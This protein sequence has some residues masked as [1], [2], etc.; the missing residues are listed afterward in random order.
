MEGVNTEFEKY[1]KSKF[2][3]FTFDFK[4]LYDS[5]SP[6]LVIKALRTAMKE[7][8]PDW[9]QEYTEW[10]ITLVNMGLRLSIGI[11]DGAWY[12]QNNG[13]P[14]GGSL[15]IQLANITVCYVMRKVIYSNESLMKDI[16]SMKRYIDD[17]AGLF[18]GD[19][20]TFKD[21]IN[22][23]NANLHSY[24]L[25]ID[26]HAIT[27]PGSFVPFLD[28]QFCFSTSGILETDLYIKETDSRTYIHKYNTLRPNGINTS[29]PFGIPILN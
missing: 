24:G 9:S 4:S 21:W 10:L 15:C 8:R 26:E 19:K 29:N 5:L 22:T 7:C 12:R 3:T 28:I 23:V 25:N 14:T 11:F 17:G 13:V 20:V 6:D 16:A 18:S 2:R 1:D 27:D